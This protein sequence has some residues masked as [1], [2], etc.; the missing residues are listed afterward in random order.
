MF[1]EKIE[2]ALI[3][4]KTSKTELARKLNS[5]AQALYEKMKK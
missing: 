1:S 4:E 2:I 3:K 5:S